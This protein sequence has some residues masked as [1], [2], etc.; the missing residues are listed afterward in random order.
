M[1]RALASGVGISEM[2]QFDLSGPS[3]PTID[4]LRTLATA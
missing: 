3:V 1:V 2:S 4:M